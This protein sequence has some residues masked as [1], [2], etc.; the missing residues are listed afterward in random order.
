MASAARARARAGAP[1]GHVPETDIILSHISA[2]L[3][4]LNLLGMLE[5][6][7]KLYKPDQLSPFN[8]PNP[9]DLQNYFIFELIEKILGGGGDGGA[10]A[11]APDQAQRA[12]LDELGLLNN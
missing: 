9:L 11:G 5:S 1:L 10:E 8:T 7:N 12:C 3:S 6:L 2:P 4:L